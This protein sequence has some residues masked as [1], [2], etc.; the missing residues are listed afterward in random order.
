MKGCVNLKSNILVEGKD[1]SI[2]FID[3]KTNMPQNVVN[4]ISFQVYTGE[5]LGIVGESGSGKSMTTLSMMGLLPKDAMVNGQ[6]IFDDKDLLKIDEEELR[7]LK[8]REMSMIFQEPMT[9]LNPTMKIGRQVE[10]MLILHAPKTNKIER[11]EKTIDALNKAGLWNAELIYEK[12]PHE[13]SGGMRQRAMIAMAMICRPRLL[14]ADEPTTA[15]DVTT[16]AR[17]L[18]LIKELNENYDATV[19]LIS[20]DLGVIKK[21]CSRALVMKDGNIV[22][23]GS[24]EDIF[25]NPKEDYTKKLIRA[26]PIID[27]A[28][29]EKDNRDNVKIEPQQIKD[30]G[31][32]TA[33]E[34]VLEVKN[35]DVFYDEQRG[36]FDEQTNVHVVKD[37]SLQLKKGETLGIVGESGSGKS[38]LSKAIVG[39]IEHYTGEINL[40]RIKPQMVFQDPYSSLNPVKKVG[41]ILEEPL[42]LQTKLDKKQRKEKVLEILK[43]IDLDEK[44]V[45]YYLSELSGGQRQR[46]AIGTALIVNSEFIVLDEPVSALDVTVQH[47]IIELLKDLKRQHKLSYLFISHDLNVIYQLCDRVCVMHKGKIVETADVKELFSNPQHDYTKTLLKSVI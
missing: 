27:L 45:D 26:I 30:R 42:K 25:D 46:V 17:I 35:L 19:I 22:E 10:E 40:P 13:L 36:I 29:V 11:K 32:D 15:L 34:L 44:Y 8:G 2:A 39:I 41:W 31:G 33:D 6:L 24:I 28:L 21:I 18:K 43:E 14:I 37:V 1:L 20:H 7:K 3:D 23:E 16:Q 47:Q 12:Y 4:D 38:T 9:S 5:I